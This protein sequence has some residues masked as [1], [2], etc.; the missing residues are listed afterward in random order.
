MAFEPKNFMY[1][2]DR[3]TS[4]RL[5]VSRYFHEI[6]TLKEIKTPGYFPLSSM[7]NT[8]VGN[9][10]FVL[11]SDTTSVLEV[12]SIQPKYIEV[13]VVPWVSKGTL[14]DPL[15]LNAMIPDMVIKYGLTEEDADTLRQ[16]VIDIP[17]LRTDI[18]ANAA[19]IATLRTDVNTNATSIAALETSLDAAEVSIQTLRTD[20]NQLNTNVG[21]LDQLTT[22]AK[23]SLVDAINEI[24]PKGIVPVDLTLTP[25]TGVV[26]DAV[27]KAYWIK[28]LQRV[29]MF[30]QFTIP[31]TLSANDVVF[32]V[33][34]L[35][36]QPTEKSYLDGI[37]G[38]NYTGAEVPVFY[39]NDSDKTIR[40]LNDWK[41]VGATPPYS[42]VI[43]GTWML[44]TPNG[45]TA[46]GA[47]GSGG[48]G[49]TGGSVTVPPHDNLTGVSTGSITGE[50]TT[51]D[52]KKYHL[53]DAGI[54]VLNTTVSNTSAAKT[55]LDTIVPG[56]ISG[57]TG[58]ADGKA[59]TLKNIGITRLD[60]NI[61]DTG[62]TTK[63]T[64]TVKT[65]I[66]SALN[67]VNGKVSSVDIVDSV[68]TD[69]GR[70]LFG[71]PIY[72]YAK[73]VTFAN[74][75]PPIRNLNIDVIISVGGYVN[76]ANNQGKIP[77][78]NAF[79]E[80]DRKYAVAYTGN[81][82]RFAYNGTDVNLLNQPA[83]VIIEY[84]KA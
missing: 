9:L 36:E 5:A 50:A 59:Y 48:S 24:A 73:A 41:N 33:P 30:V 15:R 29:S 65:D 32:T 69:T 51:N 1:L 79:D 58:T 6:D 27:S 63:L 28:E 72:V 18:N 10:L 76:A 13:G 83:V 74:V 31:N 39:F 60:K 21:P 8:S 80:A 23:N 46:G 81:M 45:I 70:K 12:K 82:L 25:A 7:A 11:A 44:K 2:S 64:T 75:I 71:K 14:L 57:E 19:N 20:V 66:V 16:W 17:V 67:E 84:T 77:F 52:G 68:E 42:I 4:S 40:T 3:N 78:L 53:T 47:G 55:K 56:A 61:T 38:Q 35:S 49:G 26:L 22:T 43:S 62:D 34:N 37:L 54:A